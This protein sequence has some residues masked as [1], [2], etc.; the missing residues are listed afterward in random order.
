MPYKIVNKITLKFYKV[1][2]VIDLYLF[3]KLRFLLRKFIL[4]GI[5]PIRLIHEQYSQSLG[6]KALTATPNP[7]DLSVISE[8]N[9][10]LPELLLVIHEAARTG[11]PILGLNLAWRLSKLFN[12]TILILDK[13]GP[14]I[15]EFMKCGAYQICAAD[16]RGRPEAAHKIVAQLVENSKFDLAI[17]NSIESSLH[18][19]PILSRH[20]I[21]T[22][23]L[24]HEFTSCYANKTE[25]WRFMTDWAGEFVFSSKL[26][27]EDALIFAPISARTRSY[28]IPQG[29]SM[30]PSSIDDHAQGDQFERVRLRRR[31]RPLTDEDKV[32]LV[33]GLG[34]I[35]LRKGVDLFI[36]TAA[37]VIRLDPGRAYRFVWVGKSYE[38]H[39]NWGYDVFLRDQINRLQLSDRLFFLEDTEYLD[40]IY[41]EADFILITSR[42]D[43]LPNVALDALD[44]GIPVLCF[45]KATGI[46]EYLTSYDVGRK[47][48]SPF[49]DIKDMAINVVRIASDKFL[50]DEIKFKNK[51]ISKKYFNF[52]SYIQKLLEL[53]KIND[54]RLHEELKNLYSAKHKQIRADFFISKQFL[55]DAQVYFPFVFDEKKIN[56]LYLYTWRNTNLRRKPIP[57]FHPGI[58]AEDNALCSQMDPYAHYL[59]SG[60]PAGRWSK[61]CINN[62][63]NNSI[64]V[65]EDIEV[66]V[67]VHVF[68]PNLLKEILDRVLVNKIRPDIFLTISKNEDLLEIDSIISQYLGINFEIIL[69]ENRGRNLRPFFNIIAPKVVDKYRYIAH[70]HTKKSPH[71]NRNLVESWR[72]FLLDLMMGGPKSGAMMDR[73][74]SELKETPSIGLAFPSDPNVIGWDLNFS[75]AKEIAKDFGILHLKEEFDFPVGGMF[76]ISAPALKEL[77]QIRDELYPIEPL[78]IDGSS[79]HALERI[80]PALVEIRGFDYALIASK[81]VTR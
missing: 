72:Y 31:L 16:V 36:Q 44:L 45:E 73:I 5:P 1:C 19:L 20:K 52:D 17:L 47:C 58:Y 75:F 25:V 69:V 30:L 39:L 10:D 33:V 4:A 57:E 3:I 62:D 59:K 18:V 11:A 64:A 71:A 66:A 14:L 13:N 67:H 2:K 15:D 34:S 50:R 76:W 56:E 32:T 6:G 35:H 43:P 41:E 46:A 53:K 8:F 26:T 60:M 78:G 63:N 74:I 24:L 80:I 54:N 51:E 77:S 23:N 79:L 9:P 28:V 40:V 48:V 7:Y 27:M 42:L 81:A 61:F 22:I 38:A 55:K 21:F 65:D 37:E 12:L 49:L 29:T 68:Y 70:L